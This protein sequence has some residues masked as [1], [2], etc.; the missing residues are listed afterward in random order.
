MSGQVVEEVLA[1]LDLECRLSRENRILQSFPRRPGERSA[2]ELGQRSKGTRTE[3]G[4]ECGRPKTIV[5]VDFEQAFGGQHIEQSAECVWITAEPGR[6]LRLVHGPA[7][8]RVAQAELGSGRDRC[9]DP[10]A[11]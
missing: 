7:V 4:T 6:E 2:H 5:F 9:G 11:A 1:M 10:F 8:E 3:L